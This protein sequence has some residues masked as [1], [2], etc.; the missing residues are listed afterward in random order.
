MA[1]LGFHKGGPNFRWP[2]ALVL[3]QRGTKLFILF[4]PMMK[5]KHFCQRGAM[6]DLAGSV[7]GLKAANF[8]FT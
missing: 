4:F 8:G 1:Y 3:T 7:S 6:A 5:N 2:L